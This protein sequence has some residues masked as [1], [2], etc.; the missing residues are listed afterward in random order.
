MQTVQFM[1]HNQVMLITS[2]HAAQLKEADMFIQCHEVKP[3]AE[4][5]TSAVNAGRKITGGTY[6]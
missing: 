5:I 3:K 1:S 2:L 4:A 6:V